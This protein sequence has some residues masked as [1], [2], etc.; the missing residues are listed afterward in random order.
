MMT[1]RTAG[2]SCR[3]ATVRRS[4]LIAPS[5]VGRGARPLVAMRTTSVQVTVT[6]KVDTSTHS[7]A[8]TPP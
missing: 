6:A 8:V 4:D 1:V 7:T 3:S 5:P 2:S